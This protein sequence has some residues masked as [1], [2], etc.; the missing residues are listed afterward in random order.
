M[1]WQKR[2]HTPIEQKVQRDWSNLRAAGLDYGDLVDHLLELITAVTEGAGANTALQSEPNS[3]IAATRLHGRGT[4]V[5][6]L[7]LVIE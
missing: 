2:C 1:D 4:N 3:E 6:R 5:L 7:K